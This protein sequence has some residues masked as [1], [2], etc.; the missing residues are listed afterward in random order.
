MILGNSVDLVGGAADLVG[1]V[2][3]KP[4]NKLFG[5]PDVQVFGGADHL[6]SLMGIAPAAKDSA[7]SVAGSFISPAAGLK[8]GIAATKAAALIL[9]AHKVLDAAT[10]DKA[11]FLSGQTSVNNASLYNLTGSFRDI[12]GE[13]KALSIDP[14]ARVNRI[15]LLSGANTLEDVMSHA[16]LQK[17]APSLMQDATVRAR[18]KDFPSEGAFNSSP[19]GKHSIDIK[20]EDDRGPHTQAK[21]LQVLTHEVQHAADAFFGASAGSNPRNFLN[22]D[23]ASLQ[24]KINDARK[25][26]DYS[27]VVAAERFKDVA[28]EKVKAAH[29]KYDNVPGEQRARFV[30]ETTHLDELELGAALWKMLKSGKTPSNWDTQE[31][32]SKVRKK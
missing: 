18:G 13:L 26:S 31:L 30:Q 11:K 19:T 16:G 9:P 25:S 15:N 14:K 1:E 21:L 32:P 8:A 28:N 5:L 23:P 29:I 10:L 12:D 17:A 4:V 3:T 2:T 7:A 22:F 24:T 6:R 20:T 27:V